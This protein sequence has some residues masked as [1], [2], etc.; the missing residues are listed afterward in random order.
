MV[1]QLNTEAAAFFEPVILQTPWTRVKTSFT[2]M[3][4]VMVVF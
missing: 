1:Q 2:V 4:I 3:N